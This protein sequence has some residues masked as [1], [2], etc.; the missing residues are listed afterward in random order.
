MW[1]SH[2]ESS[3]LLTAIITGICDPQSE[4]SDNMNAELL[5]NWSTCTRTNENGH[6]WRRE[7]QSKTVVYLGHQ[8]EPICFTS[9]LLTFFIK[10]SRPRESGTSH[11]RLG[12]CRNR[13]I[14][15]TSRTSE[16]GRF[17]G[18]AEIWSRRLINRVCLL[19]ECT[20]GKKIASECY[21][22]TKLYL[23]DN[24]FWE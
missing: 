6:G 17:S 21:S 8:D 19:G 4:D 10:P 18:G 11:I 1:F 24:G 16:H 9:L 14:L 23:N 13:I 5:H 2:S 3:Q 20:S 22:L 7:V 12:H 15:Y